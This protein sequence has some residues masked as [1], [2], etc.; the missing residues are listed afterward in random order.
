MREPYCGLA[1]AIISLIVASPFRTVHGTSVQENMPVLDVM[2]SFAGPQL[3]SNTGVGSPPVDASADQLEATADELRSKKDYL[4]AMDYFRAA[5]KKKPRSARIYNKMGIVALQ[6]S[7]LA[8]AKK[9][10]ERAMS[11]DKEQADTINNLGVVFYEIKKY[12][13]AIKYYNRAIEIKPD[14]ASYY[15]NLGAAFFSKKEFDKASTAY[16]QALR[17]DPEI[18]ERTSKTGVAAQ[19]ASPEDRAHYEY[20]MARLYAKMG[21]I[22]ESLRCLRKAVEHGY[23]DIGMVYSDNDFNELRKDP[24]FT[25]L[26]NAKLPGIPD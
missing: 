15:S 1:V 18:F 8:E 14:V 4:E 2:N 13:K 10:F 20:V 11:I 16:A 19:L 22:D 26:M 12:G 21:L 24:R 9:D 3:R 7:Y 25:K 23:K 17:L 5:L 6:T